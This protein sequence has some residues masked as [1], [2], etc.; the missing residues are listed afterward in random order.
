MASSILFGSAF[1]FSRRLI[2][3]IADEFLC[4]A[5]NQWFRRDN[6]I[7]EQMHA[8]SQASNVL[9]PDWLAVIEQDKPK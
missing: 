1:L 6:D 7:H 9:L 4:F 2:P 5:T 8:F 3:L